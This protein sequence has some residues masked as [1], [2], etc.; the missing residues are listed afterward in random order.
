M[1]ISRNKFTEK[2]LEKFNILKGL[3]YLFLSENY[4]SKISPSHL[5]ENTNLYKLEVDHNQIEYVSFPPLEYI[6]I[7]NLGNNKLSKINEE[8][9]SKLKNLNELYID[10]NKIEKIFAKA[11]EFNEFLKKLDLS[12]NFLTTT[13]DIRMLSSLQIFNLNNNKITFLPNNAFERYQSVRFK[14]F[15]KIRIDLRNNNISS[16]SSKSFCTQG[17]FLLGYPGFELLLDDI[18]KMDKCLLNHL[19]TDNT[20]IESSL[21]PSCEHLLMTKHE[22]IKLNE[23]VSQCQNPTTDI[24]KQCSSNLKFNCP[25]SEELARYSTWITGDPH[26]YSYKNRYELC[27][28][29]QNAVCFQYGDFQL[30]CSDSYAGGANKLATILV[31]V[32]FVYKVRESVIVSYE[33]N[34]TSFEDFFDNGK[35]IINKH[36]ENFAILNNTKDDM[37]V[38]YIPKAN[39]HIFISRWKSYYSIT[40]RST[41]KTYSQ[42]TGYLY[43][44]CRLQDQKRKYSEKK[45]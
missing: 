19:R 41:H 30:L 12:S 11:F 3:A 33:A 40:L 27:S 35:T 20:K 38:I 17:T 29:G 37:K 8:S 15:S 25:K 1:D 5:K 28:T 23:D 10:S 31:K 22:N 9:F 16:F 24:V 2:I 44:G 14:I 32:K 18:N 42:S 36:A 7:L 45:F 26:L 34:S 4:L 43:D 39:T 6:E 13:P 21:Q